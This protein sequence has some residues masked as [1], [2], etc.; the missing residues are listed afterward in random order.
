MCVVFDCDC[1]LDGRVDASYFVFTAT[2]LFIREDWKP[3]LTIN[4][5]IYG[6]Q[7]LFLVSSPTYLTGT[8][9]LMGSTFHGLNVLQFSQC[10]S[11]PRS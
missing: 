11:R 1:H 3:V 4:S 8:Y 10:R 5:I 6:L 7:F 9:Y 2:L